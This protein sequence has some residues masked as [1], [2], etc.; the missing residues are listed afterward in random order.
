MV[1]LRRKYCRVSL[2]LCAEAWYNYQEKLQAAARFLINKNDDTAD[3][4]M[5]AADVLTFDPLELCLTQKSIGP[6][7]RQPYGETYVV[8]TGR[9]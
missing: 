9:P 3:D 2:V 4:Y 1:D 5:K 8:G 7:F 6:Q